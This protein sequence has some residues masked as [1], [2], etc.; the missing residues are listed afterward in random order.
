MLIEYRVDPCS[1]YFRVLPR[2]LFVRVETANGLVGWGEASL[3]AHTEA[4]EGMLDEFRDRFTGWDADR[5]EDIWQHAYRGGFYRGGPV[6]MAS[7]FFRSLLS[8]DRTL[9]SLSQKKERATIMI[10]V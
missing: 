2:W 4:V 1:Q 6:M 9:P 3:E 8:L 5:I 7:F 10:S